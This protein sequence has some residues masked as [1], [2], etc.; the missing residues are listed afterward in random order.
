[1]A[2]EDRD[3]W[4]RLVDFESCDLTQREFANERGVSFSN[5]FY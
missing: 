1:M 3:R 2:A 4:K 5:L